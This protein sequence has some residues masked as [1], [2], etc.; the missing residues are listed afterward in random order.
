[1]PRG[2]RRQGAGRPVG[3][4]NR[5]PKSK[6]AVNR[7]NDIVKEL[8]TGEYLYSGAV[9]TAMELL[10][11]IYRAESLPIKIRLYAATKAV[12]H[13]PKVIPQQERDAQADEAAEKILDE[14]R[15]LRAAKV[16]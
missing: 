6:D 12:D 9:G 4:K 1:M 7:L 2:G 5:I 13:E 10:Q 16:L 8:E 14:V 3:S 11:S 15:R